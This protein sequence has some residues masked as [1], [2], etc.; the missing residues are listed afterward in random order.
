MADQGD[1]DSIGFFNTIA[2]VDCLQWLLGIYHSSHQFGF[3][4]EQPGRIIFFITEIMENKTKYCWSTLSS[5][6]LFG[7]KRELIITKIKA[8]WTLSHLAVIP[9]IYFY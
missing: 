2:P 5:K 8:H 9:T 6:L 4:S 1:T 7:D 3:E